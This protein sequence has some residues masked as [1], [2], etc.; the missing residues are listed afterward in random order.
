MLCRGRDKHELRGSQVEDDYVKKIIEDVELGKGKEGYILKEGVLY[1]GG[2]KGIYVLVLPRKFINEVLK[3][4]HDKCGH[5]GIER[6]YNKNE[7]HMERE[8]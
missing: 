8:V 4:Y 2:S 1:K 5:Q 7:I 3:E 6:L